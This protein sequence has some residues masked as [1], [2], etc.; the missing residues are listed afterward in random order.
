VLFSLVGLTACDHQFPSAYAISQSDRSYSYTA[1][2]GLRLTLSLDSTT[3]KSGDTVVAFIDEW[4]TRTSANNVSRASGPGF[5]VNGLTFDPNGTGTF[6]YTFPIGISILQ[7][8][9]SLSDLKSVAPLALSDPSVIVNGIAVPLIK[10]YDFQPASDIATF[11]GD[12]AD[13]E[14]APLRV[15]GTISSDGFWQEAR[16]AGTGEVFSN[17]TTGIYT[18]VGGDIW[19]AIAILHFTIT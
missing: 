5:S 3:Y 6:Y 18:V 13:V 1:S 19:G 2:N 7:G 14:S 9:Y 15:T 10:S 12:S 4:N 8:N 16:T 17:F 11:H